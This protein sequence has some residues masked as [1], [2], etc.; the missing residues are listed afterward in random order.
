MSSL[1][2]L[3]SETFLTFAV[4]LPCVRK[5]CELKLYFLIIQRT[6]DVY[7]YIYIFLTALMSKKLKDLNRPKT[8]EHSVKGN[9]LNK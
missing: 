9:T 7:I 4:W 6:I 8:V 5:K 2:G 3:I 1:N